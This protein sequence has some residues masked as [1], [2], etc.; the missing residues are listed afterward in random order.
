MTDL[1]FHQPLQTFPSTKFVVRVAFSPDGSYFATASYD[2][3]V[4]LYRASEH[5]QEPLDGLDE[6]DDQDLACEPRLRYVESHR[7]KVDSNPEAIALTPEWLLY[8]L[9]GSHWLHYVRLGTWETFK[10]SFNPH[11]LDTHVSFSV[12]NLA[13]H[14]SGKI[15]ACQTGDRGA[16]RILLYGIDPDEVRSSAR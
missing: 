16:E 15:I 10:K 5:S 7:V 8:T 9:R 4:V 6:T 2:R 13:I 3:H 11:P 12:L 1:I 14:P